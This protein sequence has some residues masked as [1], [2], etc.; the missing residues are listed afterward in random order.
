M[1]DPEKRRIQQGGCK[2]EFERPIYFVELRQGYR[3][4][5]CQVDG[6]RLMLIPHP[7]S[8]LPV[9]T[10]SLASEVDVLGQVVG[11]AMRLTPPGDPTPEPSPIFPKPGEFEK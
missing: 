10:F 9:Q 4:A 8:G 7:I 3:C 5:W 11:V 1:I 6:S 2:N